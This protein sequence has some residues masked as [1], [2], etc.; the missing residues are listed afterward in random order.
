MKKRGFTLIELLVVIAII[1]LLLAILLPSLAKVKKIARRVVCATNLR[2][3]GQAFHTYAAENDDKV[4]E[5]YS[6]ETGRFG[7]LALLDHYGYDNLRLCPEATKISD[8]GFTD[9]DP[10]GKLGTRIQKLGTPNGAWMYKHTKGVDANIEFT[11]SYGIN[12]WVHSDILPIWADTPSGG[13]ASDLQ[14][15]GRISD[16][17]SEVPLALDSIWPLGAPLGKYADGGE[18]FTKAE[19]EN[20]VPEVVLTRGFVNWFCLDRHDKLINTVFMDGST[21]P[22][23]VEELW[24]LRWTRDF[25][26]KTVEIEW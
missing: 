12:Y 24:L 7:F 20:W 13:K 26:K 8:N 3:I 2:S 1:A 4:I 22:V 19:M 11:G 9:Y 16:G 25:P 17:N 23:K 14:W 6:E 5:G 18:P 21:R 10:A 15:G